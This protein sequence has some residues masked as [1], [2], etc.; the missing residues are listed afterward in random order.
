MRHFHA[1]IAVLFGL[2]A[3]HLAYV[4][5][6]GAQDVA[7]L[8][9]VIRSRICPAE[10]ATYAELTFRGY[11][12]RTLCTKPALNGTPD[13][14]GDGGLVGYEFQCQQEVNEKN[15][16]I[17]AYNQFIRSCSEAK[18]P[19]AKATEKSSSWA[20]RAQEMKAKAEGADARNQ[21]NAKAANQRAGE[22]DEKTKQRRLELEE[23]LSRQRER[24]DQIAREEAARRPPSALPNPPDPT[25]GLR[26]STCGCG[27]A[28]TCCEDRS[29]AE[30]EYRCVRVNQYSTVVITRTPGA[31]QGGPNCRG[32]CPLDGYS[33]WRRLPW[34]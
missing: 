21:Q 2:F 33:A 12:C 26:C 23:E 30:Y 9:A 8:E 20:K 11:G 29:L 15:K 32:D 16:T 3:L 5:R 25:K 6:A 18:E 10:K 4:E 1:S 7:A 24:Q 31:H 28:H 17:R 27:Y 19:S 13:C 22:P 14:G 34:P